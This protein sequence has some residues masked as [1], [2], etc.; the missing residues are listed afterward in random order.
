MAGRITDR[1]RQQVTP[2]DPKGKN[3][4]WV[5]SGIP[6]YTRAEFRFLV[7]G[8]G[9]IKLVYDS[10]KGGYYTKTVDLK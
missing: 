1:L 5:K 9:Q 7:K 8:K 3:F 6:G 10:L 2:I 4:I